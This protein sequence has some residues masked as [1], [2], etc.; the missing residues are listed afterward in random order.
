MYI[1]ESLKKKKHVL[2][3]HRNYKLILLFLNILSY[4]FVHEINVHVAAVRKSC[5]VNLR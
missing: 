5:L 3:C 4:H 1:L 2:K